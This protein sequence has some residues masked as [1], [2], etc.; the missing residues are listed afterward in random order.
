MNTRKWIH[1]F[2]FSISG[3]SQLLLNLSRRCI[4]IISHNTIMKRNA[5]G[6]WSPGDGQSMEWIELKRSSPIRIHE[7][8]ILIQ[9][10]PADD[11]ESESSPVQSGLQT[12]RPKR[13]INIERTSNININKSR[14][15]TAR[16]IVTAPPAVH[17]P[18]STV[19]RPPSTVHRPPSTARRI[20]TAPPAVHRPPAT[21]HR[22]SPAVHRL[23]PAIHRPPSAVYRPPSTIRRPPSTVHRPPSTVRPPPPARR[24]ARV[25]VLASRDW[26]H[27]DKTLITPMMAADDND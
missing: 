21:V 25:P 2:C 18:P 23:P 20:V 16:H 27:V 17:R 22:L 5:D 14:S 12:H 26:I 3:L 9:S 6:R 19:H 10:N 8:L 11:P 24:R 4:Y 13:T 1:Q 15:T 7:P